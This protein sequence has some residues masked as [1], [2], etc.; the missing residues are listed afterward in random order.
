[1]RPRAKPAGT[2]AILQVDP[3]HLAKV[4]LAIASSNLA[5]YVRTAYDT[6]SRIHINKSAK[7]QSCR[8]Y[9][10]LYACARPVVK[11][12]LGKINHYPNRT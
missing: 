2:F 10:I 11:L 3:D 12:Q 4:G 7:I 5:V 8:R 9:D 6:V 1:M